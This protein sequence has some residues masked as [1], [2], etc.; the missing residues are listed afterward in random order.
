[1][2][3]M[4]AA[5]ARIREIGA[6]FSADI[7]QEMSA[8]FASL[9][10]P[11]DPAVRI[12]RDL[13]YGD[14]ERHRINM[15]LPG[16][17]ASAPVLIYVHGGGF[18]TGDKDERPGAF[19]DNVG[20]W[21]ATRGL[22]GVTINYRLA[23]RH[24]WPAGRDD[25]RAAVRWVHENIGTHGGDPA[26]LFLMGHSA[27]AAHVAAAIGESD[28]AGRLA[29]CI[30]ISG[31]YDLS[32]APVNPAYFGE[33]QLHAVRSPLKALAETRL[34]LLSVVAEY[35][36]PFIQRHSLSLWQARL[37]SKESL[38]RI[39]QIPGHNHASAT[40]H[41]NSEDDLLGRCILSF[42]RPDE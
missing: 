34:P 26:R 40:Y 41:L 9:V 14:D 29:G 5:K 19:Y 25:V 7:A 18:V 33:P 42:V 20:L 4:H 27:G 16:N 22:I 35:D 12:S 15:F 13:V 24:G 1:M 28:T 2:N 10:R 6:Q 39:F 8:L 11:A 23:P 32:I 36:P 3:D 17:A 31:I 38:P 30:G 37:A 21:A